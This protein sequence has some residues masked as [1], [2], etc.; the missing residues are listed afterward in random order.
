MVVVS[1]SPRTR[2]ITTAVPGKWYN[3]IVR[4]DQ[5]TNEATSDDAA[6]KSE[7]HLNINTAQQ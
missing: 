6:P 3:T 4:F 2:G 7:S 5:Q 1:F